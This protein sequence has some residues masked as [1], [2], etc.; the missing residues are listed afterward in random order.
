MLKKGSEDGVVMDYTNLYN[1]FFVAS[2]E[3]NTKI[4]AARLPFFDSDY[5]SGA[6]KNIV[7][8][9]EL[10]ETSDGGLQSKLPNKRILKAM[11]QDKPDVA[12]KDLGQTILPVM[13]NFMI[14]HLQHVCTQFHEVILS[15]ST[16]FCSHCKKIQLCSRCFNAEK[17]LSRSEMHTCHSGEKNILSESAGKD[18]IQHITPE[19]EKRTS[20]GMSWLVKT[21]YISPLSTDAT[22]LS[23]TEQQAKELRERRGNTLLDSHNSRLEAHD[24]FGDVDELLRQRQLGL[25]RIS[26][27][28]DSGEGKERR[29]EDEFE[30]TILSNKY[31]TKKDEYIWEIDI[32]ERMQI[33]V[34]RTGPPPTDEMS[35]EEESTWIPHQ[36]QMGVVLFGR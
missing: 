35:I 27:Y 25:E 30:P 19:D 29:L 14:V 20:K 34:E 31:K 4:I 32:P 6:A 26:R 12:V 2:G 7:R 33:S 3:G 17:N 28:D 23:V 13:E 21:Q 5:W 10:E 24:I 11:G 15:G 18:E 22:R 1:Q 8:K 9:L 16:W 36:L